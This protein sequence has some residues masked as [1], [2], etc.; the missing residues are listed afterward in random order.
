M[1]EV[2]LSLYGYDYGVSDHLIVV[3]RKDYSGKVTF[4]PF[5]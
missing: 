1:Q 2:I 5:Q 4:P 3:T